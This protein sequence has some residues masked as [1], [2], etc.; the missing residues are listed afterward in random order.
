VTATG[1]EAAPV[2]SRAALRPWTFA[3]AFAVLAL[4]AL[5]V[6]AVPAALPSARIDLGSSTP[7]LVWFQEAYLLALAVPLLVLGPLAGAVDRRLLTGGGVAAVAAGAL[8]ASTADSSASLLAGR[9]LQGA[10]SAGLLVTALATFGRM[11]GGRRVP[12]AALAAAALLVLAVAPLVGGALAEAAGWRWLFRLELA[13]AALAALLL[14]ARL[15]PAHGGAPRGSGALAAA[16]SSSRP[17]A[18]QAGVLRGPGALA[19]GLPLAAVG[20]IQAEPWGWASADTLLLLA[21]GAGLLALAWRDAPRAGYAAAVVVAGCLAAMLLFAPQY[22]ELV[23]GLSPLRSGLLT[24]AVTGPAA[25]LAALATLVARRGRAR[26][27]LAAGLACA[28]TGALGATRIDPA[29]GYALIVLSLALLGAG[30]G[31]AAGALAGGR[32][33][34]G[35]DLVAAA[36]AGGALVVAAAGALFQRA[37]LDERDS[38]GSFEDALAAGLAGSAWLLAA[39]LAVAAL[40]AWSPG[41][42]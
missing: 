1:R 31:T 7:G 19:A 42:R 11:P 34:A 18:G 17:P 25:A 2:S 6:A 12:P 37:Q 30:A 14:A 38:G 41:G 9:A 29:S 27:L 39:L 26:P 35:G 15:A 22:F 8:L 16:L 21:A 33:G 13:P 20:L 4:V 32:H 24:V 3:G 36:A 10:G 23:R 5:D 28:A 40:R